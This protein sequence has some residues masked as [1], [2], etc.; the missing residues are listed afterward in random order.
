MAHQYNKWLKPYARKLR[1]NGTPGEIK[2]WSEVLRARSFYGYEFNRQFP[3]G[4]YIVD[5]IS[6]KLKLVIEVDGWSHQFKQ[7]EDRIRDEYLQSLG[8]R[9]VRIAE[10]AVMNDLTNVVRT[11][12]AYL[13]NKED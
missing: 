9:V 11:L 4:N 2:L 12:E 3:V 1:R 5:F 6:R 8:Y 13:P 7:E 10:S